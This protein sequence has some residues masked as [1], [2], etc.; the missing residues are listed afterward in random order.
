MESADAYK[1]LVLRS[2]WS[3]KSRERYD[4]LAAEGIS[5][6]HAQPLDFLVELPRL[7]RVMVCCFD[8]R[9]DDSPVFECPDLEDVTLLSTKPSPLRADRWPGLRRLQTD[10][11]PGLDSLRDHPALESLAVYGLREPD[12]TWLGSPPRL[13]TLVLHGT[14]QSFDMS[15][16]SGLAATLTSVT[17]TDMRVPDGAAPPPLPRLVHRDLRVQGLGTG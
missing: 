7:R 2:P 3:D 9:P 17:L 12:L 6:E 13:D 15:G 8:G 16:L 5:I 4:Y 10:W 1:T 11:R 14:K